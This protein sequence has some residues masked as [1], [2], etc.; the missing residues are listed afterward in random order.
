MQERMTVKIGANISEFQRQM[1]RM[2]REFDK[3]GKNGW[4]SAARSMENFGRGLQSVSSQ[5]SN[6]G[7]TLTKSITVPAMAA[8]TA[9]GG[10]FVAKGMQRLV[11]IDTAQ[12]KL[13]A[14]GHDAESVDDIMDSALTS[15][16]GTSFGL[17]EA[18]TTAA[19]AVAAGVKPG[20]ELTRYLSLAGDAASIAGVDIQ[21]M[22]SIFNK[23]QTSNKISMGEINQL[24]ERGIPIIK[25]LAEQLG[26]TQGEVAELASK[27]EISA[28]DFLNAVEEGF[29]GAAKIMGEESFTAAAAN[30]WAAVGRIGASFLDGGEKGEG[31]FSQM[32]PLMAE[33]T[34][35]ID[36]M[37]DV[38]NE[39]GQKFGSAFASVIEKV[40][41]VI[42]W[43]SGLD[44][45]TKKLI[46][47]IAL[48]A[49]AVGP[50]LMVLGK[51]G[52]TIGHL[53][54]LFSPLIKAIGAAGG[55]TKILGVVF[56]AL[57]GPIGL[58]I[59]GIT[60]LGAGFVLVYQK[61]EPF[62]NF[63][64][65]LKARF[66]YA[67][68]GAIEF[69]DGV[70]EAISGVIAMFKGEWMEGQTILSKLGMTDDQILAVENFVLAVRYKIHQGKEMINSI[71]SEVSEF[72]KS[73]WSDISS[74]WSS[75]GEMIMSAIS[76]TAEVT[77][78]LVKDAFKFGLDFVKELFNTFSPIVMG[79]WNTLWPTVVTI[80]KTTWS[81][82]QTTIGVAMD[83]IMGI[84]SAVS[85]IIEGDWSRFG[86]ILKETALSIKDRVVEHFGN[87][88]ENVIDL[89][90]RLTGGAVDKFIEM[91]D[92]TIARAIEIF[93]GV[94]G[95]FSDLWSSLTGTVGL[96][97]ETVST[98][99][100]I[101]KDNTIGRAKDAY[102]GVKGHFQT[103][104]TNTTNKAKDIKNG[105]SDRFRE[106]KDNTINRAKELW[107]GVT[108]WFSDTWSDVSDTVTTLASGV[109]DAFDDAKNWAIDGASA[110]FNGV[111]DFM[112]DTWDDVKE[113]FDNM[114]KGAK[115][116]P[117]RIGEGIKSMASKAVDG[118][119]SMGNSLSSTLGKVV[120]GVV[121]GLNKVLGKIGIGKGELIPSIEIDRFS[122]GTSGGRISKNMLG[123]VNDRGPGNG[124]GGAVQEL[125]EKKD[126]SLYAPRGKNAIVGLEKG[127]KIYSGA[128]T[129]SLMSSGLI[130]RFSQGTGVDIKRPGENARA[131]VKK[132]SLLG[133]LSDVISNVWDYITHPKKA[134]DAIINSVSANFGS[135]KGFA[136]KFA[137]GGFNLLKETGLKHLTGIFK[138]NEGGLGSG[139]RMSFMN[140]R[141]TTPYSPNAPVPGYPT[142][143]NGGRHYGIDYGTPVGTP[144]HATTGGNVTRMHNTGGG[145][146]AKLKSGKLTQFF[147]HLASIIKTGN[148]KQGEHIAN[149][150]NSG[151]WTTGP[152]IHWQAQQ[153][154]DVL[155]RGTINP[156][157][158]VNGHAQGGIFSNRHIAEFAEEGPEAVIPLTQARRTRGRQI[159]ET[160][161]RM[162]GEKPTRRSNDKY[163][164]KT[165]EN[166]QEQINQMEKMVGLLAGIE[167]K[168]GW[169][170]GKAKK[171]IDR[172]MD[173]RALI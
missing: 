142:S 81:M 19:N 69:K 10:I 126:G 15:V 151:A 159:H 1:S 80:A 165:V 87:L 173:D 127:D 117:G 64:D 21:E 153:G 58:T 32:K 154:T 150:G 39:W 78:N 2:Q 41:D 14:L 62:R 144:V 111:T 85:A 99:F 70:I 116:L 61:S 22:G 138:D 147:M 7:G 11:G 100:T 131:G 158:V 133:T 9:V 93:N 66:M 77:M 56:G 107:S 68:T 97:R 169:D 29:G 84:I 34:D 67:L 136:G 95:W 170:A 6:I 59:A 160:A 104:W 51:I 54:V 164:R 118:V 101:M 30:V 167:N 125:I 73:I 155:N 18:A 5:I 27:G 112:S 16:K 124:R 130:P 166:Q 132:T 3:V 134:F 57:T 145:L 152:H 163:L 35:M 128:E 146:V 106:M 25:L 110:L 79:I 33:F 90:N 98:A 86:E 49:V 40:R 82:I 143:F 91:K 161:G 24:N 105:V 76:T 17:G 140:Y 26:V 168:T 46:G 89:V 74:W 148:V 120:N 72:F 103:M 36:N 38:A 162:L 50:V 102:N 119:K 137:R 115:E 121:S 114:V 71:W 149:T 171:S 129:Q 55:M 96:I 156:L 83:L 88:R 45:G 43:F 92:N 12:A 172:F 23:V 44:S 157:S 94:T 65:N 113:T 28:A 31:F 53:T 52:Q 8:A 20:E 141:M 60:A 139:K 135:L 42:T 37:G 63:I 13:K 47:Q 123:M 4:T 48:F 108:G 122:T 109:G 75:D